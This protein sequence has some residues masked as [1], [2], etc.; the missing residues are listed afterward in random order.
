MPTDF[1]KRTT[2]PAGERRQG[3]RGGAGERGK[4]PQMTE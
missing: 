1:K 2:E 4:E 3:E